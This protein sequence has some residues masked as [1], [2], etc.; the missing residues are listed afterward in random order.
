VAVRRYRRSNRILPAESNPRIGEQVGAV[1]VI[2]VHVRGDDVRHL[3]GANA[4]S[5]EGRGG[6]H[7]VNRTPARDELLPIEAGIH[8]HRPARGVTGSANHPDHHRDV[9]PPCGV[10]AGNE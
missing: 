10:G 3:F 2:P 8:E 9:H 6:S 4:E 1:K 7:V 5:L